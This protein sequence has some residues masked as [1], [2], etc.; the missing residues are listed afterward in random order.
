MR[1]DRSRLA[2]LLPFLWLLVFFAFPF[3]LVAKL[4]LSDT[5]LAVPP[6]TPRLD[7]SQSLGAVLRAFDFETYARIA[8]AWSTS[9]CGSRATIS[10]G[11]TCQK[12]SRSRCQSLRRLMAKRDWVSRTCSSTSP[13]RRASQ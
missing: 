4:S 11:T 5:A 8:A 6:Y 10:F 1:P 7:G 9:G 12:P 13:L 3:L 2:G